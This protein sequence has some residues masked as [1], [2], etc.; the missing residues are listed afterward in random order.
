MFYKETPAERQ[1]RERSPFFH[2]H[3][4]PLEE[5]IIFTNDEDRTVALNFIAITLGEVPCTL[6]ALAIMSNHFHFILSGAEKQVDRF[7]DLFQMRLDTYFTRHGRPGLIRRISAK[8]TPIAD[9]TQ[10]RNE[11]AYV[12]RNRFVV[13]TD[14]HVFAD[15]WSSGYLYFNPL[16]QKEGYSASTLKGRS[17]REFT[18]S[19]ILTNV[20][21]AI[22]VKDGRAQMWSFV[23]YQLV[24]S[25]YDNARQFIYSVLKNV[26]AQVETARRMGEKPFLSDDELYAAV[27]RYCREA[28]QQSKVYEL[29]T[30]QRKQLAVWIKQEYSAS[31]KQLARLAGLPL[32]EINALFPISA[33]VQNE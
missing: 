1:F 31:N 2:L 3:T 25:L 22:H 16:L 28:F 17:L 15:P 30:S 29:D 4:H 8:L 5:T 12:V 32:R 24:E 13:R 27:F 14:I 11:I 20:N 18:R 23:D 26:E 9:L 33:P 21:P 19:R 10:L 6:L 7:W